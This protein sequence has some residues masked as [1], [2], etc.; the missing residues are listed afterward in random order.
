MIQL[1][2]VSLARGGKTL[3][4][5]VNLIVHAK[6]KVAIVG[7]N[8][9]GKSS[10]FALL[11]G[12]LTPDVGDAWLPTHL[13]IAH[14]EQE[15]RASDQTALDYVLD[16]D[17][18]LRQLEQALA[19]AEDGL[20]IAELLASLEQ[21]DGYT[22]PAR[23]AQLLYGL[24]FNSDEQQAT[25][26]SFS[27]GWR[28]RLNLAKTLMR[29]ADVLLLDEPTNHLDL[30]AIVWL[31]QWLKHYPGTL[32]FI[33]HDRDFLDAIA[34]HIVSLEQQRLTLYTGN[35]SDFERQKA[36]QLALQQLTFEKQQRQRA[37][38]QSFIDRFKA[39]ASKATQAQSRIKALARME[40]AQAVHVDSP[41]HFSFREAPKCS[42]PLLTLDHVSIGYGDQI[43]L[44]RVNLALTQQARI[45]LIG[46]NGA[47]KSTLI[48]CLIGHVSPLT[49]E[50]QLNPALNIGYFDQHQLD[51]LDIT[52]S[53]LL[54][55]QRLSPDS[56]E[57]A[58]RS[59]L[60][61]FGFIG[62]QALGPVGP[63]SG[64]EKTR[65][66][67][68][69]LIWQKPNLLLL[70]EPTNHL[71][72]EMRHALTMALQG[73]NGAMIVVSHD[74][75][76]LRATT[77]TLLLV[78]NQ[79]VVEFKQDLDAYY[80][81]L[82]NYRRQAQAPKAVAKVIKKDSKAPS[83]PIKNTHKVDKLEATLVELQALLVDIDR[84]LNAL[85]N[86]HQPERVSEL[87]AQRSA[88]M[89]QCESLENQW[90]ALHVPDHA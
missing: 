77:D 65:L 35:Y 84:D 61:S 66:A 44:N 10:L 45:G 64:G 26:A 70:D 55:L 23:A 57:Q 54:H 43:I 47:G 85:Y 32:L 56:T 39:K 90:L 41:F 33:S 11:R 58:L 42:N 6:Q 24:G 49:G 20:H 19:T 31:E 71:D 53:A 50:Y 67:L 22:A 73:Y 80:V 21:I 82:Q 68:A 28:M 38:L 4:S 9:T 76:L 12:V 62:D 2:Q 51:S 88:A 74:R 40:T 34:S 37:H 86:E 81:W 18:E 89:A 59:Y 63:F 48:K 15:V 69:L 46:P 87:L 72:L 36:E 27:G 13:T 5:D 16:G 8:G 29:R 14:L 25:V 60:G 17:A 30:D 7:A 83:P 75:Q 79:A 1:K 78:A 52:A 3:L